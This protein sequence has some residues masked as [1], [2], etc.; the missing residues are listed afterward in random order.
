[1]VK[2]GNGGTEFARDQAKTLRITTRRATAEPSVAPFQVW[3][4]RP[5]T[6]RAGAKISYRR[7]LFCNRV[8]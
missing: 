6:N 5:L 3:E 2:N 8:T 4:I 7:N 1:M